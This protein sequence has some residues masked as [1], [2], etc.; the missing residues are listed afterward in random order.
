MPARNRIETIAERCNNVRFYS[1]IDQ[2]NGPYTEGMFVV[3]VVDE[4]FGDLPVIE[5]DLSESAVEFR[6]CNIRDQT[7]LDMCFGA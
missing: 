5:I 6:R 7:E 3:I 1:H 4:C 2:R